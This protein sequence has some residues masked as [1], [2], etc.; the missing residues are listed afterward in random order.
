MVVSIILLVRVGLIF[1][2]LR[3]NGIFVFVILVVIRFINIV[4]VK[5]VLSLKFYCYR[6]I[7]LVINID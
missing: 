1:I 6:V 5:I 2:F 3:I 7:I 4:N